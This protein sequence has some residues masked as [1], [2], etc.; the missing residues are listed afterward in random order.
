MKWPIYE[1]AAY[2]NYRAPKQNRKQIRVRERIILRHGSG[3][4]VLRDNI[5]I[6]SCRVHR[7]KAVLV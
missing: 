5:E 2:Y 1:L 6:R 7:G 3:E 4:H